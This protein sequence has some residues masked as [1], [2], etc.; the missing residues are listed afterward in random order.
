MLMAAL[1]LT[2]CVKSSSAPA[3][4]ESHVHSSRVVKKSSHRARHQES[5]AS[6]SSS[7]SSAKSANNSFVA[8]PTQTSSA[9][10]V[11]QNNQ[12]SSASQQSN[13]SQ[14]NAVNR[15]ASRPVVANSHSEQ[16]V[17]LGL[18]D[19]AVWTENGVTH[20]VDSDGMDRQTTAGSSTVHY[21]DWSG[22]L[23]QGVQVQHH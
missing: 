2:G 14:Q 23:P 18:G 11:S 4:N 1:G 8:V 19:V 5:Q 9:N 7:M 3:T 13:H 22:Q 15:A 21:Q 17:Q 12:Q 10:Q 6:S 16:H 20:H